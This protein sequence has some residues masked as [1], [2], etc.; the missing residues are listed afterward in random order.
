MGDRLN[1]IVRR[2]F[3]KAISGVCLGSQTLV[4]A[5]V[6]YKNKFTHGW[7]ITVI[8]R[9]PSSVDHGVVFSGNANDTSLLVDI[10]SP[11]IGGFHTDTLSHFILY[12]NFSSDG[13][14]QSIHFSWTRYTWIIVVSGDWDVSSSFRVA[15]CQYTVSIMKY[16]FLVA[17]VE[18]FGGIAQRYQCLW[19]GSTLEVY[20]N[21]LF[22]REA[23][24]R[25]T[26]KH[27]PWVILLGFPF[28]KHSSP[29]AQYSAPEWFAR[30][31]FE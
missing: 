14:V 23:F 16:H 6:S 1:I 9:R 12:T 5:R 7:S 27:G 13:H 17:I 11:T 26:A 10:G 2:V 25:F 22:L 19:V 21:T 4:F 15:L 8:T 29:H 3:G 28:T 20:L 30:L 24:E 31:W 18:R